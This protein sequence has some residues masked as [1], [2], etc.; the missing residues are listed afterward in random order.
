MTQRVC[1]H[2]LKRHVLADAESDGKIFTEA[3]FRM[4]KKEKQPEC[5][6]TEEQVSQIRLRQR[7]EYYLAMKNELVIHTTT[8][9]GPD[10][11]K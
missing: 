5:P 10:S 4:R 9:I 1:G 7:V 2:A 8:W 6:F 3:I 11:V